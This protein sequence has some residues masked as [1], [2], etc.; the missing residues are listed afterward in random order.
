MSRGA[1]VA[2][3]SLAGCQ[4]LSG[5]RRVTPQLRYTPG[6]WSSTFVAQEASFLEETF[7]TDGGH[8]VS[9]NQPQ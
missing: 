2:E 7:S 8:K 4:D 9:G 1:E 6:Q 5:G 3:D